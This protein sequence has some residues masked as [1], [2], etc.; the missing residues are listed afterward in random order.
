MA[1]STLFDCL[2]HEVD[3]TAIIIPRQPAPIVLSHRELRRHVLSFQKKLAAIGIT[4]H[5]AVAI[6]LPNSLECVIAFLATSLQ[7]ALCAPLN[8]AYRQSEFEFYLNDLN[9]AVV[10]V[11]KGAIAENGEAIKAARACNT[12]VAEISW[13]G[14]EVTLPKIELRGLAGRAQASVNMPETQDVALILHTSGT[15]GRP[16]AVCFASATCRPPPSTH[17]APGTINP[18]ESVSNHGQH[19]K[20]VCSDIVGPNTPGD[21]AVPCS[22]TAG[23]LSSSADE[24]WVGHCSRPIFSIRVLAR[25]CQF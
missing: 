16:K 14:C 25:L 17:A 13:D 8:P 6:A 10:L 3:I 12:A 9:A 4:H 1:S 7:R 5:D 23:W 18:Q 22:W 2:S 15:T 20:H 11:P 19:S 24:R 21:A